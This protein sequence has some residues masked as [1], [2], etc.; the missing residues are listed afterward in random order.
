MHLHNMEEYNL[1]I[2]KMGSEGYS[3]FAQIFQEMENSISLLSGLIIP[4][5]SEF[6]K[7]F[8]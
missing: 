5:L 3:T 8:L 2:S 4:E 7:N 1:E 6:Y